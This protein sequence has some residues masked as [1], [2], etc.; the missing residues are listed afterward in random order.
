QIRKGKTS[1]VETP[2]RSDLQA[3][4]EKAGDRRRRDRKL[5]SAQ[6]LPFEAC[7]LFEPGP[8]TRGEIRSRVEI[9]RRRL[10]AK[11]GLDHGDRRFAGILVAVAVAVA[12][13]R[14]DIKCREAVP[15]LDL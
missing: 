15:R 12:S 11:L 10:E 8:E 9:E 2:T 7:G 6:I 14:I 1:G 3:M 5:D 4:S 13:H